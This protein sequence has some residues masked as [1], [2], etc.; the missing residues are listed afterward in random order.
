MQAGD[1]VSQ[2]EL[3]WRALVGKGV[4]ENHADAQA[5]LEAAVAAGD[6]EAMHNL[7]YM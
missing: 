6:H 3:G 7:G 1:I 4:D 2:K 5:N